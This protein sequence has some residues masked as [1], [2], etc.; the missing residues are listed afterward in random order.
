MR[1]Q[2]RLFLRTFDW[3][4]LLSVLFILAFGV[5]VLYSTS[6]T[7]GEAADYHT[8]Q[9]LWC[10]VGLS[11]L[12]V[13]ML[14]PF[15]TLDALSIPV[16]ILVLLSLLFLLFRT[17]SGVPHTTNLSAISSGTTRAALA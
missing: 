10:A 1:A 8:R 9:L 12:L 4:L 2:Q 5:L 13:A 14:I 11:V 16:Y 17:S 7:T 3:P 6:R 15:R